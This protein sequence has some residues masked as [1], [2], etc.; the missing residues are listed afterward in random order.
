M[1]KLM[2][3]LPSG[4]ELLKET[5]N[6]SQVSGKELSNNKAGNSWSRTIYIEKNW[7]VVLWTSFKCS[8]IEAPSLYLELTF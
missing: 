5:N 7:L 8:A 2:E 4:T 3:T 6:I 1:T